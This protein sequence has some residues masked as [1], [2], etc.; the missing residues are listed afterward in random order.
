MKKHFF[1]SIAMVIVLLALFSP[2]GMLQSYA[3][4][5]TEN[6]IASETVLNPGVTSEIT[7]TPA[8]SSVK[9]SWKK[10][11]NATGYRVYIYKNNKWTK[12]ANTTKTTYTVKDLKSGTT[13]KFA[14]KAY[15]KTYNGTV[16]ADSYKTVSAMTKPGVTSKITAT[17]TENTVKLSWKKVTSATGYRVYIYKNNKWTKVADTTKITNAIKNLKSGT[18]YKFAVKAYCKTDKSIVWAETYKT[19]S[20]T[21]TQ[22]SGDQK[23][24][25]Y[26]TVNGKKYPVYKRPNGSLYYINDMG[27]KKAY[28]SDASGKPGVPDGKC[29]VCGKT[30]CTNRMSDWYCSV[31]KKTIPAYSCHPREH[32]RQSH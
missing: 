3:A 28:R 26:A 9:L 16:W 7:A 20:V 24:G 8:T 19:I 18:K 2:I 5:K 30:S 25:M 4:E 11:A 31:C 27:L 29:E 14:V 15:N 17:T 12:V 10:A 23:T 21:T 32:Y 13:Y 22:A 6:A 1:K